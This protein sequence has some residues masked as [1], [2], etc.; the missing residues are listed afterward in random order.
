MRSFAQQVCHQLY[1]DRRTHVVGVWLECKSPDRDPLLAQHPQR[2]PDRLQ[3]ALFLRVVY[4][5][6]FPQQSEWSAKSLADC[7]ERR[8]VFGEAGTAVSNSGVQ[9]I[10]ANAMIHS[11]SVGDFFDICP[12]RFA[13]SRHGVDI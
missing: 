9:E 13:N 8:D 6:H 10:T 1:G 3:K 2:L 5:L 11:N 4:P 7:N 12:T